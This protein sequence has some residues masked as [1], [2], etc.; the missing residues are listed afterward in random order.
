VPP[1]N[2]LYIHSHDT[3]RWVQ[4]YGYAVP[5]PNIQ[6]LADQGVLFREAFCAMPT[7]SGSRACLLTGQ[8]GVANGM[9]GLAHRGWKLNDYGHHL[10]HTLREAGYRSTLIGEQHISRDPDAI[11]YDEVIEVDTT[12]ADEIAPKAIETLAKTDE[13]FFASVGFFETHRSFAAPTSVRDTLYSL[14][15][16]NLPDHPRTREDI[17]AF[18]A[19]ARSLDQGIGAVL[20][21]LHTSGLAERTLIICTT[22]HG[23][24]FPGAKAT[25]YDRGTGV[26]LIMR[27]PG[28][29]TGGKVID[30]MV[31]HLDIYPTIC[32]IAG[33]AAPE[34]LEGTSLMPLVRGEVAALHDEVFTEMTYHAAYQPQRAVRTDRWKYIRRFDDYPHPVLANCDDSAS[35]ELLVECGWGKE[36]L[37]REELYDL[38]LDPGEARNVA[39]LSENDAVVADLRERLEGWMDER[40]DPVLDGPVEAPLGAVINEQDQTSPDEPTRVVEAV[41]A[42]P[43][44]APST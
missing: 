31:T 13:P 39:G 17:A 11:G 14:P 43:T 20:N 30:S 26:M 19:S 34:R 28:G 23:L 22:D 2:I 25:L 33:I 38:I 35:K 9:L 8:S 18:K 29:F 16:A 27:G 36:V 3:G 32:E 5:T 37:E 41:T 44:G 1:P 6:L 4:P 15:P 24:A 40:G 21:G 12:H 42:D 10:V 7:C